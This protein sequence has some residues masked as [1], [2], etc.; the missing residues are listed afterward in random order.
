MRQTIG[1]SSDDRVVMGS[2]ES[3]MVNLVVCGSDIEPRALRVAAVLGLPDYVQA[4]N[5]SIHLLL[6]GLHNWDCAVEKNNKWLGLQRSCYKASSTTHLKERRYVH[7]VATPDPSH[8][9]LFKLHYET[10]AS[11]KTK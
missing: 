5:I 7:H 2:L 11:Q 8:Q 3:R 4:F 1:E 10:G 9:V 6:L